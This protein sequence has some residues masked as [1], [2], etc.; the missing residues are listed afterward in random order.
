MKKVVIFGGAGSI[1]LSLIKYLL[2]EGKYEI[3]VVDLKNKETI[4]RLKKYKKRV[5]IIYSDCFDRGLIDF[6]I[7]TATGGTFVINSK[8]LSLY[9]VITTGII[10]PG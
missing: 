6:L 4:K 1:G 3:T 2:S 8:D 9:T 7:K 10:I 5:N